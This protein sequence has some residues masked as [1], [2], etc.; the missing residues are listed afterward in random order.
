MT[1]IPPPSVGMEMEGYR[2]LGSAALEFS[3]DSSSSADER[4][5]PEEGKWRGT[6]NR[7]KE[8]GELAAFRSPNKLEEGNSARV[9][10]SC[11]WFQEG[12]WREHN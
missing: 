8:G 5:C 11:C 10:D 4:Q 6:F 7:D 12:I 1:G 2:K 3:G 9:L